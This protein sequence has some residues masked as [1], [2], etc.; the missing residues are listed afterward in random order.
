MKLYYRYLFNKVAITFAFFLACI[1]LIFTLLDL[2]IHGVRFFS[3][4]LI[5]IV[6]I[7]IYYVYNFANHLEFFLPLAFLLSFLKVILDLNT[8]NELVAFLMA[9]I[10]RKKILG[11][12]FLFAG[13]LTFVSYSNQQWLVPKSQEF[14]SSFRTKHTKRKKKTD[15]PH[16]FTIPLEDKTELVYQSMNENELFDVFWIKS[17]KDL[18]HMKFLKTSPSIEGRFVD[19]FQRTSEGKLEKTESFETKSF[20]DLILDSALHLQ[21]FIPFENRPLFL[22]FEQALNQTSEKKNALCFLHQKLASPMLCF[23]VLLLVTPFIICFSRTKPLFLIT[24]ISLFV[25]VGFMTL[26]EGMFILAENQVISSFFA[27]WG[28]LLLAFMIGLPRFIKV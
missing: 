4:G 3:H 23:L 13:L 18:W 6:D 7:A 21:P 5:G 10:S 12:F 8:H 27:I 20:P 26:M 25:F 22:L 28:P 17:S 9:G 15:T 11:P 14:A 1:F 16:L 2:S 19:R 24:A